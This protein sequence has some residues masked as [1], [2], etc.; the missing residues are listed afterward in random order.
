MREGSLS[1]LGPS[2]RGTPGLRYRLTCTDISFLLE[3]TQEIYLSSFKQKNETK[4][5]RLVKY[6][7]LVTDK[8]PLKVI[9]SILIDSLNK[10]VRDFH[11]SFLKN[12]FIVFVGLRCRRKTVFHNYLISSLRLFTRNGRDNQGFPLVWC[13]NL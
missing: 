12:F 1:R 7:V 10:L 2:D 4:G 5:R 3:I 13:F 11:Y 6:R 9:N 8:T